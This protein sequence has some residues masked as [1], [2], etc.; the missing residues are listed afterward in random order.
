M[1]IQFPYVRGPG[2][3][4]RAPVQG[5]A[6]LCEG[7][8]TRT[9]ERRR[10]NMRQ[11]PRREREK[12]C[13]VPLVLCGNR[14]RRGGGLENRG[15]KGYERNIGTPNGNRYHVYLSRCIFNHP[16]RFPERNP[17]IKLLT[18]LGRLEPSFLPL[19]PRL[20]FA[21]FPPL[22]FC[23]FRSYIT[24]GLREPDDSA[25]GFYDG[26]TRTA[27]PA[28]RPDGTRVRA[29]REILKRVWDDRLLLRDGGSRITTD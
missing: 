4:A 27:P 14:S 23:Q 11:W 29:E 15:A 5:C 17:L 3:L 9:W 10:R 13:R 6:C 21:P 25:L 7:R 24:T 26:N 16:A 8:S 18:S 19:F 2:W 12:I 20:P 22:V 1:H 28:P